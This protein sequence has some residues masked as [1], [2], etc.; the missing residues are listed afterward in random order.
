MRFFYRGLLSTPNGDFSHVRYLLYCGVGWIEWPEHQR[1]SYFCLDLIRALSC[2]GPDSNLIALPSHLVDGPSSIL[3]CEIHWFQSW[4]PTKNCVT[5]LV[6]RRNRYNNVSLNLMED[7][8]TSSNA[9]LMCQA[10]ES[11]WGLTS[12]FPGAYQDFSWPAN[13]LLI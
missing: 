4:K 10:P 2:S 13:F 12:Q 9:S 8:H 5:L 6:L 7:S 3:K 11:L 1:C